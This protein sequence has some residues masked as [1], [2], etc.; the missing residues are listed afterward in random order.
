MAPYCGRLEVKSGPDKGGGIALLAVPARLVMGFLARRPEPAGGP[1]GCFA[2][3]T[4]F[5]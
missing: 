2:A 4:R 3:G 1:G 5:L